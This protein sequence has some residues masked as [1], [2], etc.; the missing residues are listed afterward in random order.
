VPA[1]TSKSASFTGTGSVVGSEVRFAFGRNWQRFLRN[2]NDVT[3]AEAEKSLRTMLGV[4]DLKGKT[5]LD[6]GS[7]SGLFSLAAMRLGAA[8]VHS[9][10]YDPESVVCAQ[11]L[12]R[13]YFPDHDGWTINQGDVLDS[14]YLADLG[15]FDIVY[16]WGVLHHT[17]NMWQA[18]DN[19][20][21]TLVRRGG[22]LFIALYN[23]QGRRSRI[24]RSIKKSYS[25]AGPVL[26]GVL[27][28]FFACYF[29][30]RGFV[31]GVFRKRNAPQSQGQSDRG[32]GMTYLTDLIDW[33]GG[34]PFEVA[35]P[36]SVSSFFRSKGFEL[37]RLNSVGQGSG[38]NEFVFSNT[39]HGSSDLR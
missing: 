15:Q 26:R 38:N 33:I 9:F 8:R 34:Y 12:K 3:I 27:I 30:V 35:A 1:V 23:D 37:L 13:R 10:D 7:G 17:G 32:R 14:A 29:G 19:V 5:F 16:S 2:L 11:E 6:I 4:D 39:G 31:S 22:M 25:Q 28:A 20:A 24:W 36:D 21:S 18:L